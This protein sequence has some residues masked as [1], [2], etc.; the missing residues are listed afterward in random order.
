M[1]GQMRRNLSSELPALRF[2][3]STN[4]SPG[5]RTISRCP[6]ADLLLTPTSKTRN[7]SR[8]GGSAN[9][10]TEA[11]CLYEWRNAV[12]QVQ[13]PCFL[14]KTLSPGASFAPAALL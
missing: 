7:T 3:A 8:Y 14:L 10:K 5:L 11:R 2:P 13:E 1:S 9:L 12:S 4:P 6:L